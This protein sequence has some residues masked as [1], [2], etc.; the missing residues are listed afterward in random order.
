MLDAL[1]V[2]WLVY[3]GA[4]VALMALYLRRRVFQ[5]GEAFDPA[6][7]GEIERVP[8]RFTSEGGFHV[9]ADQAQV[10]DGR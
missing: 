1:I 10:L 6:S 3:V 7:L 8:V 2:I 5:P 4:S 9:D